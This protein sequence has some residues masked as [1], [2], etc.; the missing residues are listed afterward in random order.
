MATLRRI[1][2]EGASS[3]LS[4]NVGGRIFTTYK[5][6]LLQ[7]PDSMLAAMLDGSHATCQISGSIFIDR[8]PE[9]FDYVLDFLR[10]GPNAFEMPSDPRTCRSAAIKYTHLVTCMGAWHP[11]VKILNS[12]TGWVHMNG[13]SYHKCINE[14]LQQCK[15]YQGPSCLNQLVLLNLL[16]GCDVI[17]AQATPT[18]IP[19]LPASCG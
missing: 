8:D 15:L 9:L 13:T 12:L 16:S 6:T 1:T 7:Y 11:M 10:S 18:R 14:Q 3:V 17:S 2:G 19:I 4:L 5:A